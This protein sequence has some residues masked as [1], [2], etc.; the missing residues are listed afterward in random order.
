MIELKEYPPPPIPK[1]YALT[2]LST[3][4][5]VALRTILVM[6]A[7]LQEFP[8]LQEISATLQKGF[9][10]VPQVLTM[11]TYVIQRVRKEEG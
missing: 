10:S 4:T 9:S 8:E 5:C 11:N 6:A 7:S 1:R 3:D 2:G